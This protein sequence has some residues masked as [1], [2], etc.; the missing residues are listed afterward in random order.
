[1]FNFLVSASLKHRLLVLTTAILLVLYGS[2]L[3]PRLPVDVLPDLTRPTVTVMAETEG[4]APEE[5]ERLVSR[6]IES[7]LNGIPGVETVRS[8]SGIGFA[9][10]IAEFGWATDVTLARIRVNERLATIQA[11]LPAGVTP[12][13]AS[14]SSIMGEILLVALTAEQGSAT[15]MELREIAD[16]VL[17]PQVLAV[18]GV[19]TF[20]SIGGEVRQYRVTPSPYVMHHLRVTSDK[21]LEALKRF[22]TNS[23][24]GFVDQN[25]R[26]YLLRN[27]GLTTSLDDLR[28][29]V[30]DIHNGRPILLRQVASVE[31]APRVKRGDAG[32]NGRPAVIAAIQKQPG[33]D[34]LILT[35]RIERLLSDAQ[36]TLPPGVKVDQ[37]QFRQATFIETSIA[38]LKK[39][40]L[41]A[42]IVV[43]CVLIVFL[44]NVRATIISL[45]AIP[46][47]VLFTVIVFHG[48]GLTINTMTLGGLAIA[49]G[50]LVDDAVV[51]V[52]NILRR[53]KENAR[54]P[55]P[56]PA[57]EVIA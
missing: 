26:E 6:P 45:A 9:M 37:V 55:Q 50:E 25:S 10:V 15:A 19:S 43:A 3:L 14:L 53:L 41:E 35:P 17:R 44:V 47:S 27:I 39:V 1:M 56:R 57:L 30:V 54:G 13:M 29:T 34:T 8:T 16:F 33:A 11:Q 51:D 38:N 31:F 4:L 21:L 2:Y 49:I 23:T 40:L 5:V 32:F 28:N 36:K 18:P 22:G 7:L 24:G 42:A 46:I 12:Q 52:E 20:I 48:F